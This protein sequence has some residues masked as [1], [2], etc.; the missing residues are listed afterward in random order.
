MG[1]FTI[2]NDV[3]GSVSFFLQNGTVQRF[4]TTPTRGA[5][6]SGCAHVCG[7]ISDGN[8]H[9]NYDA[10]YSAPQIS[11]PALLG[12]CTGIANSLP[13]LRPRVVTY[14]LYFKTVKPQ[15]TANNEYGRLGMGVK[16]YVQAFVREFLDVG[17]LKVQYGTWGGIDIG[18]YLV[19]APQ[20]TYSKDGSQCALSF[21]LQFTNPITLHPNFTNS[22]LWND[23]SGGTA[24][25][26]TS[27]TSADGGRL[28]AATCSRN[29]STGALEATFTNVTRWSNIGWLN[30][31]GT[32]SN[33]YGVLRVTH[34]RGNTSR[35]ICYR[36]C[37]ISSFAANRVTLFTT[38]NSNYYDIAN[39]NDATQFRY[40]ETVTNYQVGVCAAPPSRNTKETSK[41]TISFTPDTP[42]ETSAACFTSSRFMLL[43]W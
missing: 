32:A 12:G 28:R 41:V 15:V 8:L 10:S 34:T 3:N 39:G 24:I 18:G 11:S 22:V 27:L 6:T 36:K 38:P 17:D 20:A 21:V 9:E 16:Q 5:V 31:N 26:W 7:A 4:A 29:T 14:Q 13:L 37:N 1:N 40:L 42:A 23:V 33:P 43:G 25:D 35:V 30:G 2:A 19:D